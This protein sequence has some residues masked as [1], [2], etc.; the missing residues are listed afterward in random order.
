MISDCYTH[1]QIEN[2][3]KGPR[4]CFHFG[5][6]GPILAKSITAILQTGREQE[7]STPLLVNEKKI[8]RRVYF[9]L[10]TNKVIHLIEHFSQSSFVQHNSNVSMKYKTQ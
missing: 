4:I 7:K 10:S 8:N 1:N 2:A 5:W 3:K 6:S 9:L